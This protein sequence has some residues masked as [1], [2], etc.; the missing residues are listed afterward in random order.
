MVT[1]PTSF[2]GTVLGDLLAGEGQ[3]VHGDAVE[4]VEWAGDVVVVDKST[5]SAA[6]TQLTLRGIDDAA[7]PEW[8]PGAHIEVTLPDGTLRQYSLTG[9]PTRAGTW[10]VAVLREANGRGGSQYIHDHVSAGDK[11]WVRG[12]RNHFP[13][14]EASE[15]RFVAGGIGITPLLPMIYAVARSGAS[16]SLDY[17][18]R[19]RSNMAFLEHLSPWADRV[20]LFAGSE[21]ER[22]DAVELVNGLGPETALYCCGPARLLV[23]IDDACKAVGRMPPRVEYFSPKQLEGATV[24][25]EFEVELASSGVSVTVPIGRSILDVVR[26]TGVQVLASCEE[27]TCG[28]CEAEVIEGV[29]DHRDSVLSDAEKAQNTFM[30][31]CVSRS[32][33]RR[34]VLDL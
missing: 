28:T 3:P 31:I 25:S 29:P 27:G 13:L 24:D 34:L 32:C 19:E 11:L 18:G 2:T 9:D 30:M 8:A 4:P 20:R 22:I 26:E 12:P 6:I 10:T 21:G 17:C 1:T 15:Y 5:V 16:W 14:I 33:S 7:L 23:A